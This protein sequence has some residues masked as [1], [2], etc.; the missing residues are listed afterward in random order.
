MIVGT[1]DDPTTVAEAVLVGGGRVLQYRGKNKGG[2][3]QLREARCLREMTRAFGATLVINDR[4]DIALLSDAD[5]VHLG[6]TDLPIFVVRRMLGPDKVIGATAHSLD[7]A[8]TAEAEGADYIGFGA[9]FPTRSKQNATVR[10]PGMLG[11]IARRVAIP[12]LGIGG[13]NRHN[14]GQVMGQ[15]ALG[16]AVLSAVTA[17]EDPAAAT[18]EILTALAV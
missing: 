2:A 1:E 17:S 12:V 11:K 18:G 15:G 16:V 5:G 7:E 14:A 4:P 8:V 10:N 6:A 3:T 13:I 9:V